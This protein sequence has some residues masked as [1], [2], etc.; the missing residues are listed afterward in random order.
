MDKIVYSQL[1]HIVTVTV[2]NRIHQKDHMYVNRIDK[3]KVYKKWYHW[4]IGK[5]DVI[6]IPVIGWEKWVYVWEGDPFL[7][8]YTEKDL[9]DYYLVDGFSVFL[10]PTVKVQFT[11]KTELFEMFDTVED[12]ELFLKPI[13]ERNPDIVKLIEK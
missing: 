9:P 11:N 2:T 10:K 8:L 3:K 1:K 12:I 4:F 6:N 5:Y 13:L 7:Q